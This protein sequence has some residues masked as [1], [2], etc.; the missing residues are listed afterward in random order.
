[1]LTKTIIN[2]VCLLVCVAKKSRDL[3]TLPEIYLLIDLY[4]DI[5]YTTGFV[6][7]KTECVQNLQKMEEIKYT[8]S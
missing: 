5:F 7:E 3:E 1:M 4:I 6:N 8:H 2:I